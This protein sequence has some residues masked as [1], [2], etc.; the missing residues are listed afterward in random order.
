MI[1]VITVC[2]LTICVAHEN[3]ARIASISIALISRSKHRASLHMSLPA[4]AVVSCYLIHLRQKCPMI[5][6]RFGCKSLLICECFG[7]ISI[8]CMPHISP[9][10]IEPH[11]ECAELQSRR[12]RASHCNRFEQTVNESVNGRVRVNVRMKRKK[13]TFTHR[14]TTT[15][16]PNNE[17]HSELR[18]VHCPPHACALIRLPRCFRVREIRFQFYLLR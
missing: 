18:A 1:T 14:N 3:Y 17:K 8:I 7:T 5:T 6:M 2:M 12:A 13:I 9:R 11:K 10:C 15:P 4:L 16:P